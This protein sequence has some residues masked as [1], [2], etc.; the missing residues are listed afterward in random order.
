MSGWLWY[1][2]AIGIALLG[3]AL[4]Y[5]VFQSDRFRRDP[6]A[7]RRSDDATKQV[8]EEEERRSER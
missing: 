6:R 3:L 1:I 2:V 7:V 8:Y 4:V 5:G